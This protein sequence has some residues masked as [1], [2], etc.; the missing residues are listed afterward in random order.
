MEEIT[1]LSSSAR[2]TKFLKKND[3]YV[4][5]LTTFIAR[6]VLLQ[7]ATTVRGCAMRATVN[8]TKPRARVNAEDSA[9]A[10]RVM[11]VGIRVLTFS[12]C[13]ALIPLPIL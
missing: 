8:A 6:N 12:P 9:R 5:L 1:N 4:N 7:H 13:I 2:R 10:A 11:N 3:L